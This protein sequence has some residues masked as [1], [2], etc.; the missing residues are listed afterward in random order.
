MSDDILQYLEAQ[1]AEHL[2]K[3]SKI[4]SDAK[5]AGRG[6]SD[7]ERSEVKREMEEATEFHGKIEERQETLD[8]DA[9]I[10]KL[11]TAMQS[12]PERVPADK[13]RNYGEAFVRSN[14]YAALVESGFSGEFRTGP[15]QMPH[16]D[17]ANE[18]IVYEGQGD[19]GDIFLPQRIPGIQGPVEAPLAIASLFAQGTISRGNSVMMVRE[20]VTDNNAAIVAELG[21]KPASD[22][23]FDTVPLTL[24][25]IATVIKVSTEMLE[26]EEAIQSYLSNRLATFVRQR[27]EQELVT[28]L[29]AQAGQTADET[30]VDGENLYD[31]I[32]AGAVKVFTEGGLV[33]DA[34]VMTMLDYAKLSVLKDGTN[35]QYFSGGP[36]GSPG[37]LL[38]G[39]Y[40][41]AI[42][43]RIGAGEIVVGAFRDGGTIWRKN[44]GVT[45]D[46]TNSNEDDFLKNL[47][48][49]RAEER[50]RLFLQR[51][52][53]FCKVSLRS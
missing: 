48:A 19:N 37:R 7:T 6:L 16:F 31:A 44:T 8:M 30:D 53:A 51:P 12:E 50:V 5:A 49:I 41:V 36:Y 34:V 22:I 38:W 14:A 39:Q 47:T 45:V 28:D 17:A 18:G 15:I 10:S 11:G 24:E 23:Q 25:K 35:G 9:Q 32:L 33:A 27:E 2:A 3:A 46:A 26:D 13:A 40:R 21:P 52:D 42:S 1:K 20:S 29:L 43:E 4:T